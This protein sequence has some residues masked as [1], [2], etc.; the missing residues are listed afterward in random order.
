M[1]MTRT[2]IT[3]DH[4]K[5]INKWRIELKKRS[6]DENIKSAQKKHVLMI[7]ARKEKAIKNNANTQTL[8]NTMIKQFTTDWQ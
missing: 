2:Y 6:I 3:D 4:L 8:K 7:M 5:H 1:T